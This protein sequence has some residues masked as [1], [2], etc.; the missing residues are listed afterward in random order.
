MTEWVNEIYFNVDK[1]MSMKQDGIYISK[2][3]PY[4]VS[5]NDIEYIMIGGNYISRRTI[6]QV[7][8]LRE[9]GS[10][11]WDNTEESLYRRLLPPPIETVNH[12]YIIWCVIEEYKKRVKDNVRYLEYGVR[13]GDNFAK[14]SENV[15]E[16]YGVDMVIQDG[17]DKFSSSRINTQLYEMMTDTFRD[18]VLPYM[19]NMDIVFIDADHSSKSVIADFEGVID[20]VNKGGYIV[21][22]DTYPCNED[23]LHPGACHDC[24]KT[25]MYI[26]G[27][28]DVEIL[29][30]PLNPGVTIIRK[31]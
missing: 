26:K 4:D 19:D 21:M 10:Y 15:S 25:P 16:A 5:N 24:Y 12:T 8:W 31:C 11:E 2:E 28:Y 3:R 17:I 14:M 1:F 23:Y 9:D 13:H 20:K 7:A 30:L 27:K 18:R 6:R 22:H 29:T